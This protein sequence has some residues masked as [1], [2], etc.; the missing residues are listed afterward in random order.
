MGPH[1]RFY[2]LFQT[3]KHF[4]PKDTI[5]SR[6][7]TVSN[8]WS[9]GDHCGRAASFSV[10]EGSNPVKTLSFLNIFDV[11]TI[12]HKCILLVIAG[13]RSMQPLR[14]PRISAS[15]FKIFIT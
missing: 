8:H 4:R 11:L 3:T 6:A 13:H 10:F 5:R 7:P 9:N 12:R 2:G 15:K 1:Y 14:K